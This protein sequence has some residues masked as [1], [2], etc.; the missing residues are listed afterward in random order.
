MDPKDL[1]NLFWNNTQ[2]N[3]NA[4]T[5]NNWWQINKENTEKKDIKTNQS[6][7]WPQ[8]NLNFSIDTNNQTKTDSNNG[9]TENDYPQN[10][11][12]EDNSNP[13]N[14]NFD[15]NNQTTQTSNDENKIKDTTQ[16][17]QKINFEI[18][19]NQADNVPETTNNNQINIE[20]TKS[21]NLNTQENTNFQKE[22]TDLQKN[23]QTENLEKE[24]KKVEEIENIERNTQENNTQKEIKNKEETKLQIE[25]NKEN[26]QIVQPEIPPLDQNELDE[27]KVSKPQDSLFENNQE[28][29]KQE[30][31]NS[32][33]K[34]ISKSDN[35]SNKENISSNSN[36][37]TLDQIEQK[38]KVVKPHIKGLKKRK[39]INFKAFT[40]WCSI[41]LVL[42]VWIIT[43]WLYFFTKNP[44]QVSSFMPVDIVKSLLKIFS[45]TF[46]WFLFLGGFAISVLNW[47]RLSTIKDMPKWKFMFWLWF[48]LFILFFS[49]IWW[50]TVLQHVNEL[51]SQADKNTNDL[52]LI[53]MPSKQWMVTLNKMPNLPLIAPVPLRYSLNPE[54]INKVIAE[55]IGTNPINSV[56]LDCWNWQTLQLGQDWINFVWSCLYLHKWEYPLQLKFAYTDKT[57]NAPKE[58]ILS[59]SIYVASE[60]KLKTS[61]WDYKLSDDKEEIIMWKAPVKVFFDANEVFTDLKLW[62]YRISR[63]LDADWK[64]DLQNDVEFAHTYMKPKLQTVYFTIPELWPFVYSLLFRVQQSDVPICS[65]SWSLIKD[66]TYMLKANCTK[67]NWPIVRYNFIIYDYKRNREIDNINSDTPETK[68]T[69]PTKWDYYVKLKFI[70]DEWKIWRAESDKITVGDI[71]FDINYSLKYRWAE[72]DE[73]KD[74]DK[75]SKNKFDPNKPEIIIK[76]LPVKLK[77]DITSISPIIPWTEVFVSHMWKPILPDW[78]KGNTFQINIQDNKKQYITIIVKN[79]EVNSQTELKIP[80]YVDQTKIIWS[81]VATPDTVWESPFTVKLNASA[82]KVTDPDDKIVYFSRDFD[83]WEKNINTSQWIVEHTYTYNDLKENGEYH[84]KV[85]VTTAKWLKKTIELAKPIMVKK[86]RLKAMIIIDS[87]PWQIANVWD[88]VHF[89]I[90]TD[91][92]PEKI[93]RDFGDWTTIEMEW[94]AAT[95]QEHVYKIPWEYK[96]KASIL[97]DNKTTAYPSINLIV[98]KP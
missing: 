64:F 89:S 94:R 85:T 48:G 6:N 13:I 38:V 63:D 25:N 52:I 61:D 88:V 1:W 21:E 17:I 87:H 3:W 57:T 69:F 68:Y 84:P 73:R 2:N 39:P 54:I 36:P 4:Q 14:L 93:L 72:D 32:S 60:I 74:F 44:D 98:D 83:D 10:K 78:N 31:T 92:Q 81:L 30:V 33:N 45:T 55:T 66:T 95:Q 15:L 23:E 53:K 58:Q 46:F 42:I 49:L 37:Q 47:Y 8:F 71:K 79:K 76:S 16:N 86:P 51:T 27:Q 18:S 12:Q 97:Y 34:N 50:I 91:W 40:I 26:L 28:N 20:N 5:N 90:K 41:F 7:W 75:T 19:N 56:T 77:L 59:S 24:T 70:T 62:S 22:E 65:I 82:T 9:K 96:I 35:L 11:N 43:W 29:E 67:E 80:I